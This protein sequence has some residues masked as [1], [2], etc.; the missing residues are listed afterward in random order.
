M[1]LHRKGRDFASLRVSAVVSG[2]EITDDRNSNNSI[3]SV[4]R[5]VDLVG[6]Q[7]IYCTSLLSAVSLVGK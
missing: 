4:Y 5:D 2:A 3:L 7:W 1:V 6:A